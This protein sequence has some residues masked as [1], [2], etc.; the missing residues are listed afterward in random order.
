MPLNCDAGEDSWE[1]LEWQG[2]QTSPSKGI[3][4]LNIH[5]KDWCWSW[6]SNTL[7]TWCEHLWSSDT[8]S[9]LIGKVPASGKDWEQKETRESEDEMTKSHHWYN[10][11]ELGQTSGD[12]EG[13]RGLEC[14]SPW[15]LKE[16]EMTGQATEQCNKNP[17]SN[18][19]LA[20]GCLQVLEGVPCHMALSIGSSKHGHLLLQS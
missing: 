17:S 20:G 5:W 14:C 11:H 3:S 7:A 10:G 9:Q 8:N 15:G 6:S 4:T 2:D 1:F 18:W 16:L 19:L 12:S 13:Q